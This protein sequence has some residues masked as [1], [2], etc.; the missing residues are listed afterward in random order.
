MLAGSLLPSVV[1]ITLFL[2]ATAH[3]KTAVT[4][5]GMTIDGNAELTA[6]LD[7]SGFAGHAV[8]LDGSLALNG[9]TLTGNATD[10]AGY[11]VVDCTDKCHVKIKGPGTIV[12][13]ATA[14]SGREVVVTKEVLVRDAANW[15]ITGA[16]VRVTRSHVHDNGFALAVGLDGGGGVWGGKV[17]T[18]RSTIERNATYG[19]NANVRA[20]FNCATSAATAS[21]TSVRTCSRGCTTRAA[22]T[23]R[24]RASRRPGASASTTDATARGSR[25]RAVR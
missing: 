4:S 23:A 11:S 14:V 17:V 2:A 12:G 25:A 22:T 19:V 21:S 10:P 5:C 24:A 16:K 13:G 7:C 18:V 1:V 8:I 6:D 3:G 9:F 20:T 15:G